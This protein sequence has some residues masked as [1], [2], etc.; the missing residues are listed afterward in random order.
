MYSNLFLPYFTAHSTEST[1]STHCGNF[2]MKYNRSICG[3]RF[4]R[5]GNKNRNNKGVRE[6]QKRKAMHSAYIA[7]LA[8]LAKNSFTAAQDITTTRREYR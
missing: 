1:T 7:L 6:E 3:L 4:Y 8:Y 5:F 2:G